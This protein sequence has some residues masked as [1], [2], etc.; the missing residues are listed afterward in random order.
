MDKH[1]V[2]TGKVI[3]LT[4]SKNGRRKDKRRQRLGLKI[5]Y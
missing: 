3:L 2:E 1:E 4:H 5:K